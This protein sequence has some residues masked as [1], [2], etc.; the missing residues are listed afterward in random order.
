ME[1]AYAFALWN[2]SKGM[3]SGRDFVEMERVDKAVHIAFIDELVR[4]R[5]EASER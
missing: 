2:H 5:K 1:T 4:Q 3:I